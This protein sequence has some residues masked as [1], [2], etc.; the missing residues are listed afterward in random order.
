MSN[1]LRTVVATLALGWS[2][3]LAADEPLFPFVISYDAPGNVTDVSAWLQ[4]PAGKHGFVRNE[5]GQL[6]TD[7][8]PIRFWGANFAF[9]ACFP[10]HDEAERVA[11][12]LA[13]LGINCVRLHHMDMRSIWGHSPNK[14]T[15]APQQIE[16]LD[17]LVYQLKRHG[18]YIDMNLH[19]SRWFDK[20]EGFVA[21]ERRPEFDKGLDNF[22]PRMIE[23]Q[24]KY[25]RDLLTHLNPYLKT[26]YVH[27]PAM[28]FVEISNE[29]ALYAIWSSGKLDQLLDPY[30][31]TFR[32][33]WNGWLRRKYDSTAK[34]R[35]AWS[36]GT[37]TV[38]GGEML[39]NGA[40]AEP[41]EKHWRL[42][43]DD[44]TKIDVSI[45]PVKREDGRHML[46]L[47]VSR[48]GNVPW[49]PQLVQAGFRLKK[50]A[51]YTLAFRLRS[52]KAETCEVA[53]QMA[54]EPW[55][56][57]GLGTKLE[58]G[59]KWERHRLTFIA[60]A[61]DANARIAFT[62]LQPGVYE[63]ADVSLRSEG[64]VGL[65]PDERLENDSV[66]TLRHSPSISPASND[67]CDFLWDTERSYWQGMYRYLK[68]ELRVRSLVSGT[69][70]RYSPIHVQAG[71]DYLDGH[72]YW[73]HP[74]FPHRSWNMKDWYVNDIAMV[75]QPG[76][77]LTRLASSRV[78]G[79][80]YTVSEYNHPAPNAYAAEGFPMIAAFGAFQNWDGIYSFAYSHSR[81][82]EPRR[83]ESFFDIKGNTA[84][85]AHSPACVAMFLRGDVAP[86]SHP[87]TFPFSRE[88]ERRQLHEAQ[89]A[90]SLTADALRLDP[91][92]MLVHGT[93][94]D[95]TAQGATDSSQASNAE[96]HSQPIVWRTVSDTG[97]I[98]WDVSQ[99]DAGYFT[100]NARRSK[101]FTGFVRGRTFRLGKVILK[102]GPTR[103]DWATV[104]M[105]AIDGDGFDRPGR[106]LVAATGWVQNRDAKLEHLGGPRITLRDQW[107]REP[108][109]CEG[110]QASLTL[111]VP[112][113]RVKCYPLDEAG[114]RRAA[115][116][117]GG[118]G[119]AAQVDLAPRH[120]TV[121]YEVVIRPAGS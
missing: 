66:P 27:E 57:L 8:G 73:Q 30:R 32:E 115:I 59:L 63:L 98:C 50:G 79:Q 16:R 25:A 117:V 108:V 120:K 53:C 111:P 97:E 15:I 42:E 36:E 14:L 34:L 114:R 60:P 87:A 91:R 93:A 12:R 92:L 116:S 6:T 67:F 52:D 82:F 118:C 68:D 69:Q 85:L 5:N 89:S 21:R 10:T 43:R 83:I 112:A 11:A 35:R 20:A 103:L 95:L 49:H 88:E 81:Q 38:G 78:A 107:G 1:I 51:V 71:L 99:K 4:R 77:T 19:V 75:N 121:W 74:A 45:A 76:G 101:I 17:Y 24:K 44:R 47:V 29:D 106:I 58:T 40:F 62:Q 46:R 3:L 72:A 7:A 22:E 54:H 31:A 70:L 26:D 33:L 90:W 86:A 2:G 102:I 23:L 64:I 13:R 80:P 39:R 65:E 94:L 105:T 41:W 119:N 55:Q 100:V 28:A 113:E 48:L 37:T 56:R 109:L 110:I 84:V 96:K 18:V 104:S 61:E 9:E